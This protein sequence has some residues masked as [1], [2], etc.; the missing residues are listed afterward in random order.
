MIAEE[1][2]RTARSQGAVFQVLE[3]GGINVLANS[4]L[5]ETLMAELRHRGGSMAIR[6]NHGIPHRSHRG[7]VQNGPIPSN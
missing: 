6:Q 4:P 1:L 3:S 2:L 5:P 7:L